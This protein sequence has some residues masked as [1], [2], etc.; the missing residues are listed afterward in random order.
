MTIA[1][2]S[3]IFL[4][5]GGLVATT[6]ARLHQPINFIVTGLVILTLATLATKIYGWGWFSVFY[7]LW[8]I[9]I[10]AGLLMLRAYL[11]AEKK[12]AR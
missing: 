8:M 6:T 10:V 5:T 1:L 9:G 2:N 11:R 3:L 7:I 12:K 4:I